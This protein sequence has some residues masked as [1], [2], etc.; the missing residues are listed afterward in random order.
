MM[1]RGFGSMAP[2]R[3]E[4]D[5]R[6]GFRAVAAGMLALLLSAAVAGMFL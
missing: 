6:L 5:A 1:L 3:S 2:N 4:E